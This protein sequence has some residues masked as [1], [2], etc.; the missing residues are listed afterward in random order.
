MQ[1]A[2]ETHWLCRNRG[3]EK[4]L[5]CEEAESELETRACVCG[6]LMT[7]E[8]QATVFSYL[9]FLRETPSSESEEKKEEEETPCETRMWSMQQYG[10][11]LRW[12]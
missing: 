4:T 5:A 2:L 3:C 1:A 9:N 6:S 10:E 8:T 11:R 12:S 7:K